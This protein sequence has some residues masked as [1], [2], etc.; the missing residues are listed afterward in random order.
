MRRRQEILEREVAEAREVDREEEGEG[1][2][3]QGSWAGCH[4]EGEI[5]PLYSVDLEY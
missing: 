5:P 2:L 1:S 3:G 4:Q